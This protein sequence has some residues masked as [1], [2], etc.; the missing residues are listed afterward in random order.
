MGVGLLKV[1]FFLPKIFFVDQENS[2]KFIREELADA[3]KGIAKSTKDPF[4]FH[5][6]DFV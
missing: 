6:F 1:Q 5:Y 3:S 4:P 2:I